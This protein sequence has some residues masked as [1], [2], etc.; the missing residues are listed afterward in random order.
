[1][2]PPFQNDIILAD[3]KL[4]SESENVKGTHKIQNVIVVIIRIVFDYF[5]NH[6][7][8]QPTM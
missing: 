3:T 7:S 6:I 8:L 4:A 1:M 5:E 2:N